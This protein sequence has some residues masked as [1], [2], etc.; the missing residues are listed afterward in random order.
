MHYFIHLI[1]VYLLPTPLQPL[2]VNIAPKQKFKDS[3]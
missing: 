1:L 2:C 3:L